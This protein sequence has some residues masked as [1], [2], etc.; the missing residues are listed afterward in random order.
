MRRF[1]KRL[2]LASAFCL[3]LGTAAYSAGSYQKQPMFDHLV[4]AGV[5]NPHVKLPSPP[6]INPSYMF[7][8]C[9]RGRIRDPQSHACH[10][11]GDIGPR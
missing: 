5:P 7:G 9:G 8:G 10:G 3:V 1:A 11:P 2:V 4:I 6:H